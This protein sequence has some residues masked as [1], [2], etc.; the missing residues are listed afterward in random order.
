VHLG[1]LGHGKG[2][3]DLG[4]AFLARPAELRA[5]ARLVLAGN[6]DVEELRKAA[7]QDSRITVLPW[8]DATERD[9]LLAESDVFVLPSYAEGVPM[10]LLEA[11]ASG[12]PCITTPVGGIPDLIT[13][14]VEG[15][16]VPPGNVEQLSLALTRM[17]TDDGLRT[18]AGQRAYERAG[19]NDVHAYA[20]RLAEHYLRIAPVAELRVES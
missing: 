7:G 19:A 6:G 13:Q 16:L 9:R 11:M 1:K 4:S 17:I 5:R 8:I 15:L 2:S 14:G 3:Y 20:R 12:M 10:S 18:A